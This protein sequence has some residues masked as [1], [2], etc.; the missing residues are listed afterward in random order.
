MDLILHHFDASPFAEKIRL[1]FGLKGL[2]WS[3]VEIPMVMPKPDL[4]PLTGGYRKTPTLQMG[5]EIFCDTSLIASRLD[6][7]FPTPPLFPNDNQGLIQALASFSDRTFFEPGAALSMG[8]NSEIPEPILKDRTA[9]FE[10]MDF[11]KLKESVPHMYSQFLAQISLIERQLSDGRPFVLGQDISG[12][13]IL[14]YFPLWMARGNFPQVDSWLADFEQTL[15]W[16]KTMQTVGHGERT[17][18]DASAAL[19]IAREATP[20]KGSGVDKNP[21]GLTTGQQVTVTPADYGAVPVAGEL[22]TLNHN[23][24][25]LRR[26][27]PSVG[28][29][30]THFPR[31][32]YRVELV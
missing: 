27:H 13:D 19:S 17:D 30:N 3:S 5:A 7:E 11:S 18:L 2:S 6:N 22:I 8:L 14:F 21:A 1:I 28:W 12:A 24:V 29:V 20:S 4:M 16:E 32:G 25:T 26:H 31:S 10:F 23:Q 15:R 9:F